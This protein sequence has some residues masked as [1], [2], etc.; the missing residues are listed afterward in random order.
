MGEGTLVERIGDWLIEQAL[1]E[2]SIAKTFETLCVRLQ[3]I[4]IPVVR[5]RV[6]W[7]T[8]HPLFRAETLLWRDGEGMDFQQFD[9]QDASSDDWKESPVKWMLDHDI[10]V[11]R[12]RLTGPEPQ[13]D[14][15]LLRTLEAEGYSDFLAIRTAI[16]SESQKG[17][18]DG[19]N[20]FGL[21]VTW[22]SDRPTGFSE[23]DI[24]ALQRLQRSFALACKTAIQPRM[25]ANITNTYLGPTVAKQ[26]LAGQIQL[27]SGSRTRALVWYSD[28]RDSTHFAE[29]LDEARYLDLLNDYFG[30]VANAAIE[31]GGEVLA[32]IGDAVLAIF[33]ID[34]M[35]ADGANGLAAVCEAATGAAR[36]AR[37]AARLVNETREHEGLVPLRF[38]I[39]M[40]IGDVMFGNI[41]IARRL[42]FSVIGPTVNEVARIEKMTKTLPADVLATRAVAEADPA[43]WQGLGEH[44]LVGL[45]D[46]MELFALNGEGGADDAT[47]RAAV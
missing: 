32:F 27:G 37:A 6:T 42:S 5:G 35:A 16:T 31:A 17:K 44:P 8:L 36:G 18:G 21:Y 3:A 41:G 29:T 45:D 9:H 24:D 38:G 40:S 30:C 19:R 20:D 25:T 1:A 2:S 46:P 14:F 4:G 12:R 15:S 26:V 7:P 11:L 33:P 28:L 47:G 23:A 43:S 34:E 39:A 22:V 13:L 10:T